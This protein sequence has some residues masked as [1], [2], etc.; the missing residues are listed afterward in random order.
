MVQ[1][2]IQY[3]SWGSP[4]LVGFTYFNWADDPGD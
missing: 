4:M 3:S 2:G 1:F